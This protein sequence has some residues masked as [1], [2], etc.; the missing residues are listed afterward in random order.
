MA[1]VVFWGALAVVVYVYAGYPLLI[2]A[3][4]HLRPRPV[5]KGPAAATADVPTVSFIIAA[6]NEETVIAKKLENTLALEYPPDR[7]EIIVVS[8]GSSDGTEELVRTRFA[9]R[10]KLLALR[11]RNGKTMAQNRAV[12]T[13][14]GEIIAFS[15]ATTVYRPE[16]LRAMVANYAD[17]AVGCVTGS[18]VYGTET[19]AAVDKGRAAYWNYESFLRRNES[20]FHSVLGASGCVY[21]VRRALYTPFPADVISDVA[22]AIRTV[23]QG[24]RAVV[25]DDAIVYEPAESH[26]IGD[27]LQRRA[28]VITR[29]LRLKF[30]LRAF[31]LRHPWFLTQVL[32][33]RVL[34]WGVPFFLILAFAANLLLLDRPLYLLLFVAQ[35]GLYAAAAVAWAL[36]RRNVRV[37]GLVIPLYF[38]VVNL[39][40]LLA[41]RALLRGDKQVTWETGRSAAH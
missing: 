9:D 40:P 39:A 36:E 19:D 6:Y 26:T 20:R 28:R 31:F 27:E 34:R 17:P 21:S 22:Q 32:S 4:A 2:F 35:A 18:T 15:D 1:E 8:D 30:R 38:C 23:E 12:E 7:L 25:E 41:V 24:Y 10:V 29:G 14:R 37:P 5:R 33:H 3:L 11:G 16:T 13:A